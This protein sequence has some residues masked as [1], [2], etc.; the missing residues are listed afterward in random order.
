MSRKPGS[1]DY[2]V[3]YGRP[4]KEH[5]FKKGESG[6]RRGRPKGQTSFPALV[7]KALTEHVMIQ[8]GGKRKKVKKNV[9]GAKQF[10]NKVA[11]GDFRS[12][13]LLIERGGAPEWKETTDHGAVLAN[14]RQRITA[15]LN[16]MAAVAQAEVTGE[17]ENSRTEDGGSPSNRSPNPKAT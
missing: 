8:E 1:A 3:G 7:A 14:V 16:Q 11:S 17:Q 10:A 6:N 12:M 4:P 13:K 15:R 9:A 2:E 5:Q